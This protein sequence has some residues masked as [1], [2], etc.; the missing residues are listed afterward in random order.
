MR[1]TG[2]NLDSLQMSYLLELRLQL[3]AI[4]LNDS[5]AAWHQ[6]DFFILR[7]TCVLP[8]SMYRGK[9]DSL[10]VFQ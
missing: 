8:V 7:D 10:R 9:K 6:Q 3:R 5:G 2:A 1:N 4:F